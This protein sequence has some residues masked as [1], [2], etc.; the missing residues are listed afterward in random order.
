MADLVQVDPE[1]LEYA[2]GDALALPDEAEEQVLGADVVVAESAR[3]VDGQ[4]DD[5]LRARGQ[6]H[7]ADDRPIA[8]TDDE[9]DRRPNLGQF[10]VHVL[11]HA[12][13]DT[14]A[15]ADQ[16]EEQVLGADVVVVEPLRFVLSECQ[17]LAGPVRELVEAIHQVERPFL[18]RSPQVRRPGH[19]STGPRAGRRPSK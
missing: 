17:D 18:Y 1:R 13:R 9:L 14:L 19:A 6:A 2:G 11:E 5:A 15:L 7:L 8:A 10:D 4:L 12:C 16:A 3:L